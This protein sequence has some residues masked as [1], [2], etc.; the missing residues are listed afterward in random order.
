MVTNLNV[1]GTKITGDVSRLVNE[2][3]KRAD[4]NG[5]AKVSKEEFGQF[6]TKLIDKPESTNSSDSAASVSSIL[7]AIGR[8]LSQYSPTPAGLNDALPLIQKT[9]PGTTQLGHDHL[10]VP[11]V[12]KV[13]VGFSFGNNGGP[14]WR[15]GN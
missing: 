3:T 8:I 12:G 10:D 4:L 14:I 9:I 13:N 6:L 7:G 5:D 15:G 2:L 11:G 1:Q